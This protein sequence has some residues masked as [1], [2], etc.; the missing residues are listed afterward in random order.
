M[1]QAH[2]AR[3]AALNDRDSSPS[4]DNMLVDSDA[5]SPAPNNNSHL[6]ALPP[7]SHL[8]HPPNAHVAPARHQHTSTDSDLDADADA[9][10]DADAEADPDFDDD[11][12]NLTDV[13]SYGAPGGSKASS[14]RS[15]LPSLPSA[16]LGG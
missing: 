8:M 4:D 11:D 5:D 1:A 9:D 2:Y 12:A 14:V 16:F 13:R 10:G 3:L 6:R 7:Q 15:L